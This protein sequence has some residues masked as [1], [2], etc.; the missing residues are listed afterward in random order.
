MR[1]EQEASQPERERDAII[2]V[3]VT[4]LRGKAEGEDVD[5]NNIYIYI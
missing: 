1:W 5:L 2:T 3:F 4:S